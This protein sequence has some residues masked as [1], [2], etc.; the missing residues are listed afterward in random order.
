M[1]QA[2]HKAKERYLL[3]LLIGYGLFYF[4]LV[5]LGKLTFS[6]TRHSLYFLPIIAIVMGYGVLGLQARYAKKWLAVALYCGFIAYLVGSI[7]TYSTFYQQ[8][9][10]RVSEGFFSQLMRQSKA[11]FLIFNGFDIEPLFMRDLQNNPPFWFSSWGFD[12]HHT[13]ILIAQNRTLFYLSF[14][15]VERFSENNAALQKYLKDIIGHCT[16]HT[17]SNKQIESLRLVKNVVDIDDPTSIE[18]SSRVLSEISL[19]NMYVQLFEIKTNFDSHQYNASLA[20][21][22]DFKKAGYPSFLQYV[23]GIAQKEPWGRWSDAQQGK[24]IR[25]GFVDPLP[26]Y[27]QLEIEAMGYGPNANLPTIVRIGEQEKSL[28]IG[29][30]A[31]TYTLEFKN[32]LGADAIEIIPPK[33]IF[34]REL[35]D[36]SST[37][38]RKLGLGLMRIKINTE[39]KKQQKINY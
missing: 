35:D 7:A 20:D 36:P 25:L 11:S 22:I 28:I 18:F 38:P 16:S 33:P 17:S 5:F 32:I 9:I 34:T 19:N 4:G 21:G 37:D 3:L 30:A 15:K 27:F 26:E 39:D 24:T 6:P 14:S 10:D 12:C 31:K 13:E 29:R 23:S 8:R 2:R 1:W